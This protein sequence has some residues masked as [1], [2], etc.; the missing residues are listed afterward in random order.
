MLFKAH[1]TEFVD[2][3]A[4]QDLKV[5]IVDDNATNRQIKLGVFRNCQMRPAA[6]GSGKAALDAIENAETLRTN[7]ELILIDCHMPEMDGFELAK[8]LREHSKTA[9]IKMIMLT[10]GVVP[11]SRERC[12][13]FEI[14]RL[15][16][17][18]AR[19][20][21]LLEAIQATIGLTSESP[22][23]AESTADSVP[24]LPSLH[25]FLAEDSRVNQTLAQ[26]M[27]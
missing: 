10:S 8:R 16:L 3:S 20:S 4:L 13:E 24:V 7:F 26:R 15:L 27:R 19:P 25:I 23:V 21:D 17:K 22:P 11:G 9:S 1:R 5:L 12:Q 6:E 18:P 2:L 14:S